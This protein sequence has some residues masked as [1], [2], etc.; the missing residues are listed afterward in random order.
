[1]CDQPVAIITGGGRGIGRAAAIELASRGYLPV[2]V[3]R[4][5]S[6][7]DETIALA[8]TGEA[9]AADVASPDEPARVVEHVISRFGRLDALVNNAGFAS[10]QP[11]ERTDDAIWQQSIDVNLSSTFRFSRDAWPHLRAA[12]GA[13]V[14]VSSESTRDPFPGFAAYAAAKAGVNGLSLALA[15]EGAA[16]G[17]RVYTVSPGSSETAMFRSLVSEQQWGRDKT[18]DPADI[19]RVIA[20]CLTGPLRHTVGEVIYLKKT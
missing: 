3:A 6:E 1:M 18:L 5:Q 9:V 13:I 4:T 11:I 19:A 2:V 16:D 17:I 15:R 12:R 10:M 14:N 8:G 20:D 7:L